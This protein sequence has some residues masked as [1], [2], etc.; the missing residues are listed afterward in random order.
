MSYTKAV[1]T[2]AGGMLVKLIN[3]TGEASVIGT[4]VQADSTVNKGCSKI[5]KDVPTP[6]GV[7]HEEGIPDGQPVW[8]CIWGVCDVLY[9]NAAVRGQFARGFLTSDGASY[10][11]GKA[12]C[13]AAPTS[14]FA[15][16]KHFYEI[17]HVLETTAGAGLASTVLH[18]L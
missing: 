4:V 2:E 8:V 9:T 1:F 17:G 15:S 10:V 7:I 18:F 16:D 12:L 3:K 11:A 5:V 6:I 14:P 13:E